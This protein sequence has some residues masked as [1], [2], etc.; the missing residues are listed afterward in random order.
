MLFAFDCLLFSCLTNN[1]II[2]L[3]TKK[4]R[5]NF[6]IEEETEEQEEEGED[7]DEN[8]SR[9]QPQL[10]P[11][12]PVITKTAEVPVASATTDGAVIGNS[13]GSRFRS[14]LLDNIRGGDSSS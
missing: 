4:K 9:Q 14:R 2:S 12:L 5:R 8:H 6:T 1:R 10:Q 7:D 13:S 3:C 11:Q